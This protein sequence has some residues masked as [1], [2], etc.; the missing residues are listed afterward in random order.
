VEL[1]SG[2]TGTSRNLVGEAQ[3]RIEGKGRNLVSETF[4][5]T[6]KDRKEFGTW[7]SLQD[8]TEDERF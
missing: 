1:I 2:Q 8:R 4:L 3:F 5:R 6:G 7:S